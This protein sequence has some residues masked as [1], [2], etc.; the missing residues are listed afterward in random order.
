MDKIVYV[1]AAVSQESTTPK[2]I[3]TFPRDYYKTNFKIGEIKLLRSHFRKAVI[4]DH[5]YTLGTTEKDWKEEHLNLLFLREIRPQ[6]LIGCHRFHRAKL[7]E[8]LVTISYNSGLN[9]EL[10]FLSVNILDRVL[11]KRYCI[12]EVRFMNLKLLIIECLWIASKY[13]MDFVFDVNDLCKLCNNKF[14]KR[15]IKEGE[16]SILRLLDYKVA[17]VTSL[18]FLIHFNEFA[19]TSVF[20]DIMHFC[21]RMLHYSE[22]QRFSSSL[23]AASAIYLGRAIKTQEYNIEWTESDL[24]LM[25]HPEEEIVQYLKKAFDTMDNYK[26]LALLSTQVKYRLIRL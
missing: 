14:S 18:D 1:A 19:S 16:I 20:F 15:M 11:E 6:P 10:L 13:E 24:Q 3:W 12:D 26:G 4:Q 23:T 22:M 17:C 25:R 9:N 2:S 5:I 7:V 8:W 21:E